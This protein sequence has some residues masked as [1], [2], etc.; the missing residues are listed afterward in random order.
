MKIENLRYE[1][2][3]GLAKV[4]ATISWENC[5]RSQQDIY[6][7]TLPEYSSA[8]SLKADTYLVACAFLAARY[9]EERIAIDSPVCPILLEGVL[10]NLAW[11]HRYWEK[12]SR[13]VPVIEAPLDTHSVSR[14]EEHTALFISG[15]V[16]SLFSLR[17]NQLTVPEGHPFSIRDVIYV[18]GAGFPEDPKSS[19]KLDSLDRSIAKFSE[20]NKETGVNLIPV[21][22]NLRT[23]AYRGYSDDG[24][25]WQYCYL[26]ASLA[27]VAHSLGR[28][29]TKIIVS[30]D[31][32]ISDIAP[33]DLIYLAPNY[34]SQ[35]LQLIYYGARFSR[36][37]KTQVISDWDVGLRNLH[38]CTAN[39]NSNCGKC[40]KCIVTMTTLEA[41]GKLKG[42]RAFP[43][44][45]VY[46]ELLQT[47]KLMTPGYLSDYSS[48]VPLLKE[49]GRDDLVL[50]IQRLIESYRPW[51]DWRELAL[52]E[53]KRN[54]P[55]QVTFILA[56]QD[57]WGTDEWVDERRRLPFLEKDG[58]YWGSPPDDRTA[59]LELERLKDDGATFLVIGWPAFWWLEHYVDFFHHLRS[60]YRC[61]L[62]NE[63]LVI[64]DLQ[65]KLEAAA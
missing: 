18:Q 39:G 20:V 55:P 51:S 26:G 37:Q 48:L 29:L 12:F 54:I 24:K 13:T 27:A 50:A 41:L 8:L 25:F 15:G 14:P 45:E 4:V 33:E 64:F 63:R 52:Q 61:L 42:S 38:V 16:D 31:N 7:A 30:S 1:N 62:E 65:D 46:P 6:F 5:N 32:P 56:D 9:G 28:R 58:R 49:R 11:L 23:L 21:V 53:I 57:E 34:N 19:L 36:L 17:H 59:I 10:T 3:D 43:V 47:L 2:K 44:D 22:S 35:N 60:N 40:L